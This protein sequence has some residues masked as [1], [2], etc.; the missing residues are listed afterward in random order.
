VSPDLSAVLR[1]N[2]RA[3][4]KQLAERFSR[5]MRRE[6]CDRILD[7]VHELGLGLN[8]HLR[9]LLATAPQRQAVASVGLLSRLDV[10]GLLELLP[11]RLAQWS[12]FYHDIIV[13]QIAYG[14]ASDRGRTLLEVLEVLAPAAVPQ[15][16]D[17]IG[18]SGDRSAAPPLIVRA[19][20]GETQGRSP[21]LQVKAR[22]ALGRLAHSSKF[23]V[24]ENAGAIHVGLPC[25]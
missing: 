18:M 15:T 2:A 12:Q 3:S 23:H 17:E 13:R 9:E 6:E 16:L 19:A 25:E 5:A 11:L 7:L 1:R 22:E 21:L 24:C 4:I 20:A 8:E 14:A 10:P